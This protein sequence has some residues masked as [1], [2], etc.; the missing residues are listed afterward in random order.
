MDPRIEDAHAR[1]GSYSA[2]EHVVAQLTPD[3]A[4]TVDELTGHAQWY[5]WGWQDARPEDG[6]RR[7]TGDAQ[8]FGRAFGTH[9]AR[10]LL[11]L[12]SAQAVQNAWSAWCAGVAIEDALTVH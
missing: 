8:A 6:N 9:Y 11:G 12:H 4:R 7:I 3:Q 2:H 1:M 10:H 5:A